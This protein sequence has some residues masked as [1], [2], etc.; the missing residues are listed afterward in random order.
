MRALACILLLAFSASLSGCANLVHSDEPLFTRADARGAPVFRR[1][2][3]LGEDPDCGVDEALPRDEWP[4]CAEDWEMT[5]AGLGSIFDEDKEMSLLLARGDPNIV[6][7]QPPKGEAGP[8]AYWAL[9]PTRTDGRGRV[10]AFS[11]WPVLCGPPAAG[12]GPASPA[13]ARAGAS[14]NTLTPQPLPGLE[15]RGRNCFA[16][17][18]SVVREAARLSRAWTPFPMSAHW[19]RDGAR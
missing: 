3:W 15:V 14:S 5:G 8:Y 10:T 19:V 16:A 11:A 12:E 4:G 13:E 2:L 9:A 17:R 1:G 18:A 6:Q 7:V